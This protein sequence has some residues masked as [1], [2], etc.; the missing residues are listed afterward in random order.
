[1]AEGGRTNFYVHVFEQSLDLLFDFVFVDLLTVRE[2]GV[3]CFA[4][5]VVNVIALGVFVTKVHYVVKVINCSLVG[6]FVEHVR[7]ISCYNG[8]MC[9]LFK[10]VYNFGRILYRAP[11]VVTCSFVYHFAV[12]I[13]M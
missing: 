10:Y 7:E 11:G 3:L 9:V 8:T 4:R 5:V 12:A 13:E 6:E 2:W 1:M